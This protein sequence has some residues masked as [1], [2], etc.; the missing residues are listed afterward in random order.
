MQLL[1]VVSDQALTA[2]LSRYIFEAQLACQAHCESEIAQG[3]EENAQLSEDSTRAL[4]K[5][6]NK[7]CGKK[8]I[9]SLMLY[10]KSMKE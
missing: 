8:F 5:Q 10:N 2:S 9:K 6:C 1:S 4:E 7:Q 3:N